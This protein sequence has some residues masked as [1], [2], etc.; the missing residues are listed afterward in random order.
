MEFKKEESV[1]LQ[2]KRAQTVAYT[3]IIPRLLNMPLSHGI[4]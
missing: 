2:E 3:T 4:I 1:G